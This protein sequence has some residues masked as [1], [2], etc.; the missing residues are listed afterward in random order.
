MSASSMWLAN[1]E[2]IA[3]EAISEGGTIK[4]LQR[5]IVEEARVPELIGVTPAQ[6]V[7]YGAIAWV[8][9]PI[10]GVDTTSLRVAGA[11]GNKG[12]FR[13]TVPAGQALLLTDVAL[14]A[15]AW[16]SDGT[17]FLDR[18]ALP[19]GLEVLLLGAGGVGTL[20]NLCVAPGTTTIKRELDALMA[21]WQIERPLDRVTVLR[22]RPTMGLPYLAPGEIVEVRVADDLSAVLELR[23]AVRGRLMTAGA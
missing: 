7:A 10:D 15:R 5:V 11:G 23:G 6:Q 13:Y 17:P 16:A 14:Y 19:N 18:A 1:S 22:W 4:H 2:F 3:T 8:S 9:G 20:L 12:V 21:G